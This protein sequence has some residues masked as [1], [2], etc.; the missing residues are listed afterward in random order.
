[1][2]ATAAIRPGGRTVSELDKLDERE[3]VLSERET[4]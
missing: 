3:A 4:L 1:M 2:A